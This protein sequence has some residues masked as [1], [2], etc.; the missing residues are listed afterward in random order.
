MASSKH[1]KSIVS[2][3]LGDDGAVFLVVGSVS[4]DN[5]VKL[6]NQGKQL[7][8][9]Q[10]APVITVDLRGVEKSDNSGLVLLVIWL[11]DAR[12]AEKKLVFQ[13]VPHFL[14]RMAEVF[15]LYS[16]L[17]KKND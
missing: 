1:H 10:T 6:R 5:V 11:Q 4:F 15:G 12:E 9:K 3:K 14:E 13:N 7:L 17:F 2:V 16:L 8:M